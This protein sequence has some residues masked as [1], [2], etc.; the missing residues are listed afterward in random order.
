MEG[1]ILTPLM[2]AGLLPSAAV[3]TRHHQSPSAW[4]ADFWKEFS[5]PIASHVQDAPATIRFTS[6]NAL[7]M[8]WVQFLCSMCFELGH[9]SWACL[10]LMSFE[11]QLA[12]VSSPPV[13]RD[14]PLAPWHIFNPST[15]LVC[16]TAT[17]WQAL[18][19]CPWQKSERLLCV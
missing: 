13:S 6:S 8:Q 2:T 10:M 17:H 12:C 16:T 4:L 3:E 15:L 14:V 19:N 11:N 9:N 7:Q 1:E 5:L 18:C